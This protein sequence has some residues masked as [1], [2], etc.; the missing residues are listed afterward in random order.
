MFRN[1]LL[2]ALC[3]ISFTSAA[4]KFAYNQEVSTVAFVAEIATC[5]SKKIEEQCFYSH[6]C[7]NGCCDLVSQTCTDSSE[8]IVCDAAVTCE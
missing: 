4:D 6:E 2:L 7:G 1:I 3:V 5:G 8:A